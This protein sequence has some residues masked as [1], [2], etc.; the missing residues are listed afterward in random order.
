MTRRLRD[1]PGV[2]VVY[3][4]GEFVTKHAT[5]VLGTAPADWAGRSGTAAPRPGHPA[6]DESRRGEASVETFTVE[7][8]RD[9]TPRDGTVLALVDGV[10]TPAWVADPATLAWLIDPEVQPVGR[11]GQ[12]IDL[13]DGRTRF[14]R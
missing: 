2:G 1:S 4:N 6:I 5:V 10:R 7:L 8:E 12:L 3:A 11:P 9:G 14:I 13:A